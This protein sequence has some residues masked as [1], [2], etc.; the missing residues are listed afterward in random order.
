LL[1]IEVLACL[2]LVFN[3]RLLHPHLALRTASSW[4]GI[5][6]AWSAKRLSVPN[7]VTAVRATFVVPIVGAVASERHALALT[8]ALV[9]G[10]MDVADG[11]LARRCGQSTSFGAVFDSVTDR[12]FFLAVFAGTV[13]SGRVGAGLVVVVVVVVV[14]QSG[15]AIVYLSRPHVERPKTLLGT[16]LGCLLVA[17]GLRLP[18]SLHAGLETMAMVV[19]VNS[20]WFYVRPL[21]GSREPRQLMLPGRHLTVVRNYQAKLTSS[22]PANSV[23]W[24]IPNA[25]TLLRVLPAA[26]GIVC[27]LQ[28]RYPAAIAF[29]ATFVLLDAV[30]GYLAR[31]T[32]QVSIVGT[33]LDPVVDKAALA[34]FGVALT[35]AGKL[36]AWAMAMALGRIALISVCAAVLVKTS[37]PL[38]RNWWSIG[39]NL[40]TA[41]LL[42]GETDLTA[43]LAV[44]LNGQNL[45]HYAYWTGQTLL[46]V[47]RGSW[48]PETPEPVAAAPL[49][50]AAS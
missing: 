34:G 4:L 9:F 46:Q 29:A 13:I 48:P 26:L 50:A 30:D 36:P 12:A 14:A 11:W 43:L 27:T 22:R 44:V 42:V 41:L 33:R 16:A 2:I 5:A 23:V 20:L 25:I 32:G 31:H 35:I 39:A 8:I 17:L 1:T 24:T 18:V 38:P 37:R 21:W 19:A 15:A 6:W 10:V 49:A 7:A 47:P 3:V 45:V 40:A 28:S